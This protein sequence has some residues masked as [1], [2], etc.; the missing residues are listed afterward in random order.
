MIITDEIKKV[1]EGTAFISLVTVGADGD[2]HPIIAGKGD[3]DGDN[4]VFGIYKMV[5]TQQNLL[6]NPKAW[7]VVGMMDETGPK[8]YRLTG[9]A[10]AKG[11]QLIFTAT[12]ADALI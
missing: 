5:V 10:E 6:A 8:G 9:T 4:V 2:A 3:V 7:M 11:Q 12:A 1:V